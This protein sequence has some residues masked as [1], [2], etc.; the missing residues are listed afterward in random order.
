MVGLPIVCEHF[1]CFGHKFT[2]F[3]PQNEVQTFARLYLY[4]I[5]RVLVLGECFERQKRASQLQVVFSEAGLCFI[6]SLNHDDIE[7]L[8][9][10]L[11]REYLSRKVRS[12]DT[13]LQIQRILQVFLF[14]FFFCLVMMH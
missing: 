2:V 8:T 3:T 6:Q 5:L 12:N 9:A 11:V 14:F 1:A 7:S 10:S 13:I 4:H